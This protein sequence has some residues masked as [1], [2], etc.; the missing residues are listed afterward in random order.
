MLLVHMAY[1][2]WSVERWCWV[3]FQ[4]R[5]VLLIFDYSIALA[6][7]AGGVLW[8]F[9]SRLSFPISFSLY[10]GDGLI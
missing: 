4:S 2:G 5:G 9:F 10:L 8:I 1:M 3:N 6:V 7:D